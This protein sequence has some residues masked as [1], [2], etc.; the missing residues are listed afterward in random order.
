MACSQLRLQLPRFPRRVPAY[1]VLSGE[2]ASAHLWPFGAMTAMRDQQNVDRPP[3][4]EARG[5]TRS[6][7]RVVALRG[8]GFA[9]W[10]GDVSA[11]VGDN[12]GG[13]STLI[14]IF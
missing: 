11:L 3:L 14:T 1:P 12:G 4:I 13:K 5:I 2:T 7:G 10:P 6:F 9:A 8:A